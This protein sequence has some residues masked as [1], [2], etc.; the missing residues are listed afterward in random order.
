MYYITEKDPNYSIKGSRDPLGL[1]VI[2]QNAGRKLIPYLST[3]SGSI[4]DFQIICLA[5][6]LKKELQ[7][8]DRQ[9]EP[10][11]LRFEQMMDYTRYILAP[12]EGF[13]GVE[14][15]RKV[16]TGNPRTVNISTASADFILVDTQGFILAV[17]VRSANIS[18]K[19]GAMELLQYIKKVRCL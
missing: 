3:V 19:A 5:C 17:W 15:V 9:F 4:K 18:E 13:S 6:A 10:F 2:W 1:Q 16:M 12:G 8:P 11:F 7:I 14:K